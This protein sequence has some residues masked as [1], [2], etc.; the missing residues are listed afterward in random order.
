MLNRKD[1]ATSTV[2]SAPSPATSGTSLDVQSGHGARFPEA[3]FYAIAHF[4]GSLP[5]VDN[6]EKILVTA[7]S[8]DTFTI[9]RALDGTTA[10]SI[11]TGWRISNA[12]FVE[13]MP[14]D[15][16][17]RALVRNMDGLGVYDY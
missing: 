6:A 10:Q 4:D 17:I 15:G 16:Q 1:L 11:A 2:A 8:G 14:S 9:V 7:V 13:D 12:I 3:P 5:T